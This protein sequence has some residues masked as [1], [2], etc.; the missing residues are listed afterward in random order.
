M[1]SCSATDSTYF[2]RIPVKTTFRRDIET[3]WFSP[4]LS[5]FV[6]NLS[7]L[8]KLLTYILN[9]PKKFLRKKIKGSILCKNTVLVNTLGNQQTLPSGCYRN[10][11]YT[12]GML[13]NLLYFSKHVQIWVCIWWVV[14]RYN[15]ATGNWRGNSLIK[16]ISA[17]N[18]SSW[19]L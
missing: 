15:Y 4:Y 10:A 9:T 13:L 18:Y 2:L 3:T 17:W 1:I 8:I 6:L 12:S 11:W 14:M 5:K 7:V 16:I 19:I